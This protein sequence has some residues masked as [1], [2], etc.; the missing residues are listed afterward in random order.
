MSQRNFGVTTRRAASWV[1]FVSRHRLFSGR[2]KSVATGF[3]CLVSRQGGAYGRCRNKR[4]RTAHATDLRQCTVM[5]T[6]W[7]TVQKKKKSTKMTPG[8]WA[9]TL[10]LPPCSS[11]HFLITISLVR[12]PGYS[13]KGS[14]KVSWIRLSWFQCNY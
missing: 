5:C 11:Q 8:I 2:L 1:S 6:V 13:C 12:L 9:V 10:L 7:V 3:G 14:T 4:A